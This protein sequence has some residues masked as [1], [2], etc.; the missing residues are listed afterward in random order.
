MDPAVVPARF[1]EAGNLAA[2]NRSPET[3]E[4]T[5]VTTFPVRMGRAVPRIRLAARADRLA[6]MPD[7]ARIDDASLVARMAHGDERALGALHDRHARLALAIATRLVQDAGAAGEVVQDAFLDL[8]R[9][10]PSYDADRASVTTWLVRLV[11]LR[12]IDRLRRDGAVRRGDGAIDA[13]LDDALDAPAPDD[14]DEQVQ[15]AARA[16]R[17]RAALGELGDEQR[18]IVELAFLHGYSHAELAERLGLPVGTVKTRCFRGLARLAQL[19]A[20]ER[21]GALQ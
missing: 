13:Q 5:R 14:V 9:T 18:R 8:W 19:L 4:R 12:A 7:L 6:P 21:E 17:V 3:C 11:R 16:A 15:A 10:A 1:R 2:G 20:E